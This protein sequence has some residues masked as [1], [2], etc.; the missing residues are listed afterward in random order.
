MAEEIIARTKQRRKLHGSV[1]WE[2]IEIKLY[3]MKG[4]AKKIAAVCEKS[5]P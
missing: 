4:G 1:F 5:S 3:I 2:Q